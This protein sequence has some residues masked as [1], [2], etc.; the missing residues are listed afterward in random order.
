MEKHHIIVQNL[1][2]GVFLCSLLALAVFASAQTPPK[3]IPVSQFQL[4]D[5]G[6]GTSS[7]ND[8]IVKLMREDPTI[9]VTTWSGLTLPGAGG[10][11]PLM[12][13]IAGQTAPDMY[14]CWSHIIRTDIQQGFL[15]PL[16]EWVGDDTNKNNV[17]DESEEKWAGWKN[18][19]AL[20]R[21]IA[22]VDGKVYGLPT[23]STNQMGIIFR[24][25]LVR[26]AGL[27][28]NRPPETWDEFIYWCQKLTDPARSKVGF[29]LPSYGFTW[30]SWLASAGG[31]PVIQN[32]TSLTT[33][34]TYKFPMNATT[35]LTT[36][37]I[38]Y[39]PTDTK[40]DLAMVP[41]EWQADLNSP[42]A[43]SAVEM[44]HRLRWQRWLKDPQTGEPVNL[45]QAE[46]AA[47]KVTLSSGRELTFTDAQVNTGMVSTI[48]GASDNYNWSKELGSG[49]LAMTQ[50]FYND[51]G[52]AQGNWG[53]NP[54]L[55]GVFP[56][57]GGP[58]GFPIIQYQRHFAVM[59]E[60]VARRPKA[61]RDAI[62]KVM[63][64]LVSQGATDE[65]IRKQVLSGKA[66]FVDP[67]D[68][69]RL[70]F[71][72]YVN[73]V[74]PSLRK[75]YADLDSGAA[76]TC[77][78]PFA[79]FWVTMDSALNSNVLSLVSSASGE[80]FDYRTALDEVNYTANSGTMFAR[81]PE[82]LQKFRPMAWVIFSF[83]ALLVLVMV[84]L[85]VRANLKAKGA[86]TGNP[87]GV[88]HGW[89]PW[90]LLVPAL[91]SIALWGYYPLLRG[92]IMA[93]QDYHI[94]GNSPWV[95]LDNFINIFL[96]PDFYN[97]VRQT[98]KFVALNMILVF[99]TPILLS[100]LL[101]EIPWGKVFWRSVFFLPQ[102]TSG[103]VVALLWK[104]MY[105]PLKNGLF[106]QAL[107]YFVKFTHISDIALFKPIDWLGDPNYAMVATIIPSVWAGMG[108]GSLIYLAAMKGIP[109]ELYE[110]ADLD[111]G[112]LWAKLRF[113]TLPQ[114]LPLIVINFVGAFIGTFQSMGNIFLL[115]FGGPGKETMVLSMA[116]W[117]EAYSNLRF[118]TATAM[119]WV[120]GSALIGFAYLQIRILR[121]V[122]F[123]RVEE[124]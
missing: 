35:Y 62:W 12:M 19:P 77:T 124:V 47:K 84:G 13:S 88:F 41:S 50:W 60:G 29:A 97:S 8:P 36:D 58:G 5:G 80:N 23:S 37:A 32:K 17:L 121:Q 20:S 116:I 57:P 123:R 67:R 28:P 105:S 71:K 117:L 108:M 76:K 114:L 26:Q 56:V 11:T 43:K 55:L 98:V 30:L 70:G 118:S 59:T 100:V 49:N 42:A 93:F 96:N 66:R 91:G 74:P 111:G 45:T 3:R 82:E 27:D 48:G 107:Y 75:L 4:W 122:E 68:L 102:L 15:Y 52:G 46:V 9:Q 94:V 61:E 85:I 86:S 22:T 14:Y 73:D 25:D 120:M 115:T 51:L 81:R 39:L 40:E 92:V 72:D 34:K 90:L 6:Q 113:I 89:L 83:V 18:Q 38:N 65:G 99:I 87:A 101:A 1:L 95:G 64:T 112:N 63:T 79:G 54:D 33:G 24:V 78:E 2:L 110:A 10:R 106:N 53:V 119:A 16:N 104:L 109:E 7:E 21:Q 31:T 69:V 44:Y 103:L